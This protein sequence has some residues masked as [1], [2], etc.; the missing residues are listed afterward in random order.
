MVEPKKKDF[1]LQDG[2]LYKKKKSL[3]S[4]TFNS[5]YIREYPILSDG[6]KGAELIHSIVHMCAHVHA[7]KHTHT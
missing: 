5:S 4:A 1:S 7:R 2:Y 6:P 3:Y